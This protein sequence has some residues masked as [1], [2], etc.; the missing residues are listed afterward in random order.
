MMGILFT[1]CSLDTGKNSHFF[2]IFTF[3][4][5]PQFG[6]KSI[7]IQIVVCCVIVMLELEKC[8]QGVSCKQE[9]LLQT[10]Q[11]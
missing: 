5:A 6:E 10:A 8:S 2:Y 11:G 1:E 7:E 3:N 9:T 4:E